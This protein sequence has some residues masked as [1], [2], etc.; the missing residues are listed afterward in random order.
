MIPTNPLNYC[1]S[2]FQGILNTAFDDTPYAGLITLMT[3]QNDQGR[4]SPG[5]I[6]YA[7]TADT[8]AELP[9]WLRNYQVGL[10]VLVIS[11]ADAVEG[12]TVSGL[13]AHR[14]IV[15]LV[16]DRLRDTEA[17]QQQA[18]TD[19]NKV[20]DVEPKAQQPDMEDRKF[21]TEI[22]VTVNLVLDLEPAG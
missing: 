11:P 2:L 22:Q 15:Q 10:T 20:Y 18:V 5:V 12:E 14:E 9:N 17:I 6:I 13:T 8:P 16:M 7:S 4:V 19:G 1:E 21:G 3:G